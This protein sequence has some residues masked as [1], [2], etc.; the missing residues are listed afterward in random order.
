[1]AQISCRYCGIRLRGFVRGSKD[2]PLKEGD[3]E[4]QLPKAFVED[5]PKS[6]TLD[7]IDF[8]RN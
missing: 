1:M 8:Y 4:M 5:H 3:F 2:I 6:I 7:W